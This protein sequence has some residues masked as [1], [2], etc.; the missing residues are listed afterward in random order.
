MSALSAL[1]SQAKG[2]KTL[3]EEIN[4]PAEEAPVEEAVAETAVAEPEGEAVDVDALTA[5]QLDE[6]VKD[7]EITTPAEWKKWKKDEKV[8]WLKSQFTAVAEPAEA[9][10]EAQAEEAPAVEEPVLAEPTP[11]PVEEP[12]PAPKAKGSIKKGAS[13]AIA[14]SNVKHGELL[15]PDEFSQA[16]SE[17]ENLKAKDALDLVPKLSDASDFTLFKLGGVLARI[18]E[19]GWYKELGYA[20]FREYIDNTQSVGYRTAMYWTAIY[21][22]LVNSGVSYASVASVKWSKLKEIAKVINPDNVDDWV[23][24]ANE[25]TIDTLKLLIANYKSGDKQAIAGQLSTPP[26]NA[27][28][29]MQFKVHGDQRENIEAALEKA[30]KDANTDVNTVALEYICIAFNS[31]AV[32]SKPQKAVPLSAQLASLDLQEAAQMLLDAFPQFKIN[33]TVEDDEETEAA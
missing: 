3:A 17:I 15:S 18:N 4:P 31:N 12:A 10:A 11:A 22:D 26:E 9:S 30:K 33:I 32:A 25:S 29:T 19:D 1:K 27:I 7:N 24:K 23:K 8:A 5:K 21:H 20:T 2:K 28:T 16:V 14:S 13:K 6:L